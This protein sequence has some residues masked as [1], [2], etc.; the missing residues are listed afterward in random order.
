MSNET[1]KEGELTMKQFFDDKNRIEVAIEDMLTEFSNK[2][3]PTYVGVDAIIH[4]G[5]SGI[6]IKIDADIK[7]EF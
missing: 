3:S 6:V 2:Y 5:V 1:K 4:R 7:V